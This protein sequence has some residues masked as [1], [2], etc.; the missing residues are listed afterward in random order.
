[1]FDVKL[2]LEILEE[3]ILGV[4]PNCYFCKATEYKEAHELLGSFTYHLVL[5]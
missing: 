4:A 1:M 3:E 2:V 5:K